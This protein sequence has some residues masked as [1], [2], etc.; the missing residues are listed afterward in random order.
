MKAAP[1]RKRASMVVGSTTDET[2][3]ELS[4]SEGE[5]EGVKNVKK[6]KAQNAGAASSG[7]VIELDD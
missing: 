3:I 6:V 7:N 2:P 4:D 1:K 5:D